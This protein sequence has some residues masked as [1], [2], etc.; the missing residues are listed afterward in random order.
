MIPMVSYYTDDVYS[1]FFNDF[2][3]LVHMD[4]LHVS[5]EELQWI[6]SRANNQDKLFVALWHPLC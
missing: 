2:V 4:A 6:T 1:S 3:A 5:Q